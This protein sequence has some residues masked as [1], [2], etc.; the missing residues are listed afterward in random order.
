VSLNQALLG[1][2]P[3][4]DWVPGYGRDTIGPE[5]DGYNPDEGGKASVRCD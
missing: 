2:T 3:A 4:F 1:S 5:G